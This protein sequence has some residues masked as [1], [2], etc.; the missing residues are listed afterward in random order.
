MFLAFSRSHLRSCAKGHVPRIS[1]GTATRY[2]H[3]RDCKGS[4]PVCRHTIQLTTARTEIKTLQRSKAKFSSPC[5]RPECVHFVEQVVEPAFPTSLPFINKLTARTNKTPVN[6]PTVN[7]S[8]YQIHTLSRIL[9]DGVSI[10]LHSRL[11]GYCTA[12]GKPVKEDQKNQETNQCESS[13]SSPPSNEVQFKELVSKNHS[14][15]N[16][17]VLFHNADFPDNPAQFVDF[18]DKL[19]KVEINC[20]AEWSTSDQEHQQTV[21]HSSTYYFTSCIYTD[22][23]PCPTP[24]YI[25]VNMMF[26]FFDCQNYPL[27]PVIF[28]LHYF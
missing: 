28:H 6:R 27:L 14:V 2:T 21:L 5:P 9:T 26:L 12:P 20:W 15:Q 16:H 7:I 18:P 4:P 3:V 19:T 25:L 22:S 1:V 24:A 8:N 11:K 10:G 23:C 17:T 13:S